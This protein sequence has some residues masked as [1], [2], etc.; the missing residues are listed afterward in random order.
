[1][2]KFKLQLTLEEIRKIRHTGR[3]RET[4]EKDQRV[5]ACRGLSE[6]AH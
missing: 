2:I 1:M 6:A 5:L 3:P 4:V